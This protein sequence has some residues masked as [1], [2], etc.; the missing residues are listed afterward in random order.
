MKIRAI[1]EVEIKGRKGKVTVCDTDEHPRRGAT[2]EALA[3]LKPVFKKDGTV[4]AG[5]ASGINDGAA[6]AVIASEAFAKKHG[7]TPIA[8]IVDHAVAAVEPERM[9]FGPVPATRRLLERTGLK[10]EDFGLI[11]VNEAFAAQYLACEKAL[12]LNREITNVNG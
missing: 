11:E 8:Y 7:L 1:Q 2:M 5:N 9:G 4:T 3:K 10:L 6:F 12:G